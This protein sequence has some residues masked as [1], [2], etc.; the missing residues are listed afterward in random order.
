VTRRRVLLMGRTATRKWMES[1][2]R[3]GEW[4]LRLWW[5]GHFIFEARWM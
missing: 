3:P 2:L 4:R 5:R 1:P